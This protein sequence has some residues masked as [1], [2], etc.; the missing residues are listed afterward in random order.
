MGTGGK[1]DELK[2]GEG[3]VGRRKMANDDNDV[4]R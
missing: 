4:E 2:G 1:K 3:D